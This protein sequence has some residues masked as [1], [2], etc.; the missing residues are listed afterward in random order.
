MF[1]ECHAHI[2]MNGID[3]HKAV[4][5]HQKGPD[6]RCIRQA[7][8]AY[9]MRGVTFVRDGG[10]HFGASRLAKNLAPEYGITYLT[11]GF[12]IY[13]AGRY[14]KV[15]G[16]PFENMCEYAALVERLAAEGGDF[17]K[18][19]TTGIMDFQTDDGLTSQPLTREEVREMV[20][21]AHEEGF[22]VM[23]HTNGARAVE[24]AAEAGVDSLE[25]G[26]FQDEDSLA[27]LAAHETVW[28][29][30]VV[31]VR[32]LIGNGRF[33]DDVLKRIWDGIVKNLRLAR[34]L[35]VQM[36]LGS[37]AGAFRVLHGQ[38]I[39]DEYEAFREIFA[40]DDTILRDLEA[41]EEKIRKFVRGNQDGIQNRTGRLFYN[42]RS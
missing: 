16:L 25:H 9:R 1:G 11:P 33:S 36:A 29:P 26:N 22:R 37:D 31:T 32:N 13:K 24:I 12:A 30:T 15:A 41:G 3:Y 5:A 17:V 35:G 14:G 34:K 4:Q 20:H 19:M 28:V 2:F 42:P 7:L 23:S 6:E 18:I 21:I 27:C 40:E 39:C 38:G 10:D 8:E